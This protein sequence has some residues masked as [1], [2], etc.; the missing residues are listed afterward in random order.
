MTQ[1]DLGKTPALVA[2]CA[3][4]MALTEAVEALTILTLPPSNQAAVA[5]LTYEAR[6]LMQWFS[7]ES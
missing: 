5:R 4:V 1:V 7:D 3:A 2:I 6:N